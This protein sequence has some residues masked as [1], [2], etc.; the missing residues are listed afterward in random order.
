M[1]LIIIV[2]IVMHLLQ[3]LRWS[4]KQCQYIIKEVQNAYEVY[5]MMLRLNLMSVEDLLE[6][7][8]LMMNGEVM[9]YRYR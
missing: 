5:E 2:L 1:I 4:R 3:I 7:H 8:Y 9:R 6:A